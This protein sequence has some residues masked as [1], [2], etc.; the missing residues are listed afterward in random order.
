MEFPGCFIRVDS[1]NIGQVN[2]R[3]FDTKY[4]YNYS[5]VRLMDVQATVYINGLTGNITS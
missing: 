4:D 2:A 3:Y 1:R 5:A